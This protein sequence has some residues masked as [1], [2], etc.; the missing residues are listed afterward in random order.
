M[1]LVSEADTLESEKMALCS[2][3]LLLTWRVVPCLHCAG[4][5]LSEMQIIIMVAIVTVCSLA[6]SMRHLAFQHLQLQTQQ[7]MRNPSGDIKEGGSM[8]AEA[9]FA[10]TWVSCIR[11]YGLLLLYLP[12]MESG[13]LMVCGNP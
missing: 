10:V 6:F 8:V 1:V 4:R 5:I 9:C 7:P 11:P 2:V 3:G 13:G 12:C